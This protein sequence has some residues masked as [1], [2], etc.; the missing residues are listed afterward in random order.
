MDALPMVSHSA[1]H[2]QRGWYPACPRDG[3]ALTPEWTRYR[4]PRCAQTWDDTDLPLTP[5]RCPWCADRPGPWGD[6]AP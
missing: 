4:C 3:L 5:E 1:W 6:P 2:Q